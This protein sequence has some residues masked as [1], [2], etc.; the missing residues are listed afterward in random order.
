M[1]YRFV[2]PWCPILST[3]GGVSL[4]PQDPGCAWR[5]AGAEV[6]HRDRTGHAEVAP[7]DESKYGLPDSLAYATAAPQLAKAGDIPLTR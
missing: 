4:V 1:G 5:S 2:V 6:I 7:T 3:S